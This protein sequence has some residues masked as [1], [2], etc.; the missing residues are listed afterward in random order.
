MADF[1]RATISEIHV[2]ERLR[3]IDQAYVEAI[4]ASMDERGQIS[5][6][7]LRRTP[8]KGGG[9]TPYTLVAGGY[10]TT[11]AKLLGWTEIDAIVVQADALEAQLLE[12]SENLYRNEL[13]PLDRAIFVMKYREL[14]E[15]RHGK[16]TPGGDQKSKGHDGPLIFAAGRELS[17]RVCEQLGIAERTYKRIS[18]IGQNLHPTL[19]QALRGTDAENDQSKLLKLAKL[20]TDDQV[21]VAAALKENPD[22]KP[23]LEWL[24]GPAAAAPV[25][26]QAK[27]LKSLIGAWDAADEDTRNQFLEHIGMADASGQMA[28][29][30]ASIHSEAA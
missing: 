30:M 2:G 21:K 15:E 13:N 18:S 27:L 5:P 14:W 4:A 9:K 8:A 1:V 20:P 16:I 17:E 28:G 6:I 3:P 7:M 24:K 25:S 23:V 12:I 22:I 19:R 10:R 11:A 29:L 26:N